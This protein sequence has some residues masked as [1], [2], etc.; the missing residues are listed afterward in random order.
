MKKVI[1]IILLIAT[2]VTGNAA[3]MSRGVE[4]VT[5]ITTIE[6]VIDN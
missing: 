4:M 1:A 3:Q 6:I 2:L 5:R